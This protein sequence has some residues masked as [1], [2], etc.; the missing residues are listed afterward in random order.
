MSLSVYFFSFIVIVVVVL[1]I[2]L[3]SRFGY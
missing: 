1:L 2:D 3:F